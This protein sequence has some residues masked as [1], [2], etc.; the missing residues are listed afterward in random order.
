MSQQTGDVRITVFGRTD[1]GAVRTNNEDAFVI[2]DLSAA[3]GD[4]VSWNGGRS[5]S[6][7]GVLL[8]VSDGMGGAAAGEIASAITV[9][10]L[11]EWLGQEH[12]RL[13]TGDLVEGAVGNANRNVFDA[14]QEA[15]RQGMGA[16]LTAIL[17]RG[18]TAHIAEVG[19]SRAYL[20]RK[21]RIR[22][23]TRDQSFV[24]MLVEQGLI[25]REQAEHSPYKNVILQA[26]GQRP[27]VSVALCR[28]EL[29]RGDRIVLCSDGL[30]NKVNDDEIRDILEMEPDLEEG[31]R[32]VDRVGE[33]ARR[34][35]Q[36]YARRRGGRWRRASGCRLWREHHPHAL[37]SESLRSGGAQEAEG[38]AIASASSSSAGA[39]VRH[40]T[41]DDGRRPPA[42]G[43][44]RRARARSDTGGRGVPGASGSDCRGCARR[45]EQDLDVDRD[46]RGAR[47]RL[48]RNRLRAHSLRRTIPWTAGTPA[49]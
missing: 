12:G 16:T 5:L 22:Q 25:T 8:A 2:A 30:T 14:A 9:E 10:S 37:G 4:P 21:G 43:T 31:V 47:P 36:H 23:V 20:I 24:E 13:A 32:A 44:G 19:D 49:P 41:I 7:R 33:R 6:E 15:E 11:R 29:R 40:H 35:G 46:R 17:V 42:R 48:C 34:R 18:A 1:V 38:A 26:M 3:A 27:G 39:R 28:L 45:L